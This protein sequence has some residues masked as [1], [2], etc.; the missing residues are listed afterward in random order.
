MEHRIRIGVSDTDTVTVSSNGQ[1]LRLKLGLKLIDDAQIRVELIINSAIK[2][3]LLKPP[4]DSPECNGDAWLGQSYC[5][6]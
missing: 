1:R 6:I 4:H 5:V 3:K 2:L